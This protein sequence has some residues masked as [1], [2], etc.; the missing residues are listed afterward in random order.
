MSSRRPYAVAL[1]RGGR[2]V[3]GERTLVMG[4]LNVTPDSFSDGGQYADPERAAARALD[5]EAAGADL[6][7]IGGET[8]RPGAE[9]VA[10]AEECRRVLPVLQRL[11]GRLRVPIS[12]D[13]YKAEVA[14][15]ALGAGAAAVNDIS[16]LLY[17]PALAAV[18]ARH[19]AALVLMHMRGRSRDMYRLAEYADAVAEVADELRQAVARAQAGG[20]PH[21]SLIL[22]PGIGF[23][24][25][26][27]HSWRLLSALDAAP[28]A[29]LD[30]PWLVGPS[31]KSFLTAVTGDLPPERRGWA[32]A[33][34]VTAAVLAGAH[35]VRVHD[36]AQMVQVVR[37]ADRVL[38]E[39]RASIRG[40]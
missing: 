27:E 40:N 3:L 39:R 35:I 16:G 19:G 36:V 22:D 33:A 6:I 17:D 28:L 24:K 37:V 38:A 8:T 32:T 14:D 30:R 21:E 7:D 5:M 12:V 1:A 9:P 20:V 4:I 26:A 10:A 25:K 15:A 11:H 18:V 2:L 31:R 13:T 23:A 29:A 34:A